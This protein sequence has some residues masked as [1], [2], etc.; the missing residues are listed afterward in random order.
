MT[1]SGTLTL[2]FKSL[3]RSLTRRVLLLSLIGVVGL[4][5]TI[6]LVFLLTLLQVQE[7]MDDI[8]DEAVSAFDGFFQTIQ[9]NLLAASDGFAARDDTDSA[10]LQIRVRNQPFLDVLYVG[11]DGTVLAQRNAFGRPKRTA[12]EQQA[13]LKS[14]PPYGEVRVGPVGFEGQLPYVDMAVTA[15]DDIGL[16]AGLLVARVDLTR[17]WDT[18][19]DIKVGKTGYAYIADSSG[20]LVVSRNRRL[21]ETGSNLEQLVG[22]TPQAIAA[23][24]PSFYTGLSGQPVVAAAQPLRTV[25][26]FAVVEQPVGEALAPFVI[27][28]VSLLVVVVIVGVLL[29]NT[30]RF[31]RVRILSPL[32]ALRDIVGRMAEGQL[33]Q[34]VEVRRNDELG[35]LAGSFNSMA[36]QLQQAFAALEDRIAVLHQ[37]QEALRK[38]E[39]EFKT[40]VENAPDVI[41]RF[42][43]QYRHIYVNPVVEKEFG[44]P[45]QALLGKSHRQLGRPPEMAD[46]SESI[47]RQVFESGR[48]V[49]FELNYPTPGGINNYLSRGVP[50]FAPDGSV[51]SA[52][53][54]HRNITERKRAESQREAALEALRATTAKLETLIQVSPLAI[55][56]LDPD[57][58]VQL[59]NPSAERIFGWTA[60][61]AVGHPNPIVPAAKQAEYAVWSDQILRGQ[62]LANQEAVRQRKDGSF[63]DVSISSAPV[64]DAMGNLAGRMAIVADITERKR[65]ESQKEAALKALREAQHMYESVFRL[66][67][68]IIV[69]T[70]EAEGRYLAA[71]DAHERVTGYGP[72][73]VIGHTMAEF[74]VWDSPADRRKVLQFVRDQGV[75]RNMEVRF[76]RKS[77]ERFTALLS[78][79]PVEVGGQR[80]LISMVT[81]I[82][83]RKRAEEARA[84]LAT[85]IDQAAESIVITDT[86]GAIQY[87]NPAFERIT[88]YSQA[89]AIG[90]NPRLLKSGKQNAAFYEHLWATIAAGQVW[91]GRLVNRKKDGSFFTEE[92]TIS[93]VRDESGAIVNY[94]AVKRDVTRELQLEEQY[95]QAQKMEAV[96]RLTAGVAHDFNNILTAINGFSELMSLELAPDHPL[97]ASVQKVLGSGQRAAGLVRQL[98]AFSRK[99]IVQPEVLDLNAVLANVDKMLRRI[100][101]EDIALQ[102]IPAPGLWLTRADPVQVEQVILNLAVN[103]R[104]AM[105]EGGKLTI[106]TA[107]VTLDEAYAAGHLGAQPG[108]YALLAISDTGIGM[109]EEVKSHLFEPF[110]TTK[111]LGRGTGLGLATVYGIVKQSGGDVQV[112]SEAGVGTTFKV[113]LPR[114]GPAA[115]PPAPPPARPE[116]PAGR[117]TVLLVEDDEGARELARRVLGGLGYT[118]LEAKDGQEALRLAADYPDTIH[119]LLTDVVMPGMGGTVLAEQLARS[120]PDLKTL[121][122]SGYTDN[123]IAHH[124]V[125]DPGIAFLQK[126]FGPMELARKVRAVLNV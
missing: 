46:W 117:E 110:F 18:T 14:P 112:Y 63:V 10:L 97:Q 102:T 47:I 122:M 80:C 27:P 91:Q 25:S 7:R 51:E 17:L 116:M 32:L 37:A 21:L 16:P 64:Y 55:T 81:D 101:G 79:A 75:V 31:T 99:Q 34:R 13:W 49:V 42:D 2:P 1:E 77:G 15:T 24:R 45:P 22:R 109:N 60:Q 118:L 19:L 78:V 50:E 73:E 126:P 26:W 9:S 28:A 86:A 93:P 67:P 39:R 48:E 84:R 6:A 56:L 115:P 107:N 44:S 62:P 65:A 76:H 123:A 121:Y 52:L 66:S 111:E 100:I 119:L 106:E 61:E 53:F 36:V 104:D 69:V 71:N 8:N 82:T 124:G 30:V 58:N 74:D 38:R 40:L 4:C 29:Y 103:A 98:M 113:Y 35:Q 70:T 57:G 96:G 108:E 89:E 105:P 83:E 94:V 11:L 92:A 54:I 23:S 33:E 90:Q 3:S 120:R 68:E 43:R 114:V 41:V 20:Q 125:L 59:W 85:A 5:G 95:R 87:V 72:A 88:G 12:I